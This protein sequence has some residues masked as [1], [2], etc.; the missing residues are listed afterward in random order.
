MKVH[1]AQREV[2]TISGRQ[3]EVISEAQ[4]AAALS[5][6]AGKGVRNI[7]LWFHVNIFGHQVL[8]II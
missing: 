7:F 3:P 4:K 6:P 5:L 2:T 8:Q 1:D